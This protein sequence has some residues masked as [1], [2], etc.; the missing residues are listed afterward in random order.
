[1]DTNILNRIGL[2]NNEIAVYLALLK[3]SSASA[4]ELSQKTGIYRPH[5]YDKLET[6]LEKGLISYVFK[7]KKKLFQAYDPKRLLD[8]F[9]E[10]EARMEEEKE[11]LNKTLPTLSELFNKVEEDTSVEVFKGKEGLKTCFRDN[12]KQKKEIVGFDIDDQKFNEIAPIFMQQYFKMLQLNGITERIITAKKKG[13]F[14]FD[15]PTTEYRFLPEKALNPPSTLICGG[16]ILITIFGASLTLIRIRNN[17]LAIAYKDH[18][19]YLWKVADRNLKRKPTKK[20]TK[21]K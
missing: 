7:G 9:N 17:D 14:L 12:I 8:Y 2:S 5:V 15:T 1:M 3:M 13:V 19:E 11:E 21:L 16:T 10:K 18:F 20:A 6:L 4:Y